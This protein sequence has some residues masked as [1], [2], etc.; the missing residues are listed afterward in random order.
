MPNYFIW[1][2]TMRI[3][4]TTATTLTLSA[5]FLA[6]TPDASALTLSGVTDAEYRIT[7][8]NT[9]IPPIPADFFGPGSEPFFT[10][11]GQFIQLVPPFP[12]NPPIDLFAPDPTTP[13]PSVINLEI[14]DLQLQSVQPIQVDFNDGSLQ[15]FDVFVTIDGLPPQPSELNVF[16]PGQFTVD[17][18]FDIAYQIDFVEPGTGIPIDA[19]PLLGELPVFSPPMPWFHD[20]GNNLLVP[21]FDGSSLEPFVFASP[22]EGFGVSGVADFPIPLQGDL[23]GDGFVGIDDLNLVLSN[24]NQSV[25]PADP[26]ADPS[27]DGFVGIDDLNAVLGN[28]NASAPPS[29]SAV[30]EPASMFVLGMMGFAMLRRAR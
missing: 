23:D 2:N 12:P 18:F 24:W 8:G 25:P 28:W 20:V 22:D 19:G 4:F 10:Q 15:F 29:A 14:V 6:V 13:D 30:P 26:A 11:P 17:S 5:C 3:G 7:V 27:G 1:S 9:D 16:P 21:G